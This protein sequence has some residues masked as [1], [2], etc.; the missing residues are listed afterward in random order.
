MKKHFV[1]RLKQ[2]ST[3]DEA[4]IELS[5]FLSDLYETIDA[6]TAEVQIGGYA[7]EELVPQDLTTV[8]LDH[9]SPAEEFNWE[10]QWASFAPDF[11]HGLAHIDLGPYGGPALL[12]KPGGGFGDFSHPTTRLTLSLMASRVPHTTVFDIG[13][14]SGIL[15]IAAILLGADRAFGIDIDEEALEHSRENAELNHVEGKTIFSSTIDPA[16]QVSEPCV[17]IM[18]MIESEQQ[19]AWGAS[20]LLHTRKATLITS[21]ILASGKEH[22]LKKVA[23]WGWTLIEEKEEDGWTGFVFTQ[24]MFS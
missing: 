15:S 5:A 21:G 23:G 16:W 18:N 14:G 10:E 11:H 22:Y 24:N 20:S 4:M 12:L 7:E 3:P 19:A 2:G 17:I 8:V 13:C 1:F 9:V 6:E